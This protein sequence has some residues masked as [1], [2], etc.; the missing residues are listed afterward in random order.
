M[1]ACIHVGICMLCLDLLK[2]AA[3]YGFHEEVVFSP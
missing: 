3:L 1:C 2:A